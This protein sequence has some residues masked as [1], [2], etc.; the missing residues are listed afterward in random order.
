MRP[1]GI[2]TGGRCA[3]GLHLGRNRVPGVR[4]QYAGDGRKASRDC[5]M[6]RMKRE[7]GGRGPKRR[8]EKPPEKHADRRALL[9]VM[10]QQVARLQGEAEQDTPV[11][12]GPGAPVPWP[13]RN[14]TSN[15]GSGWRKTPL[16]SVP[17]APMP[18]S[19]WPNTPR[20]AGR[21]CNSTNKAW[22]LAN[23]R[24]DHAGCQRD[25]GHFWGLLETRPYLRT[26]L[27]LAHALWTAGRRAEAVQHL[28]DMLRLN[29]NDNQGVR[30]TLARLLALPRPERRSGPAPSTIRRRSL[31][32]VWLT[33][34]PLS[35]S[36]SRVI[37]PKPASYSR[38]PAR[39]T[40][41]S[42]PT[43]WA[44]SSRRPRNPATTAP[45]TRA[46]P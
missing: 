33:R 28:Q 9:G 24:W 11:G 19:C 36:A 20:A 25:V 7:P 35:P 6:A 46:R 26:R 23:G 5:L 18:M 32:C 41:T 44:K 16:K 12:N 17:I 21:P 39:R 3:E 15:A 4:H 1:E 10:H 34:R 31:G 42:W 38:R 27:G 13:S 8:H 14:P 43:C 40:S 30:Y 2:E 22:P 37:P 45:A 29:P